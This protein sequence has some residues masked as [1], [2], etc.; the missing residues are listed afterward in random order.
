MINIKF[1]KE[2]TKLVTEHCDLKILSHNTFYPEFKNIKLI[3]CDV[4]G[5][6]TD[7]GLYYDTQGHVMIKFSVLDGLGVQRAQAYDLKICFISNSNNDIIKKRAEVL[8]V[9]YCFVGID[10]KRRIITDLLLDLSLSF[11]NVIHIADDV[12]DLELLKVVGYP[13]TVPNAVMDVK[14]GCKYITE[15]KGGYGA[16]RDLC[17]NV[18]LAHQKPGS[19]K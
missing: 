1:Q 8:G 11:E 13:V 6:M 14:E 18:I 4:D 7:G 5:I 2:S 3:C 10:D 16:V 12:N 9:D 19:E 17:E 15:R